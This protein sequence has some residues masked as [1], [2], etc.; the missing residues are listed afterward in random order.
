MSDA[1]AR[2]GNRNL[3]ASSIE[4]FFEFVGASEILT[5]Q[6]PIYDHYFDKRS[7]SAAITKKQRL[8]DFRSWS[9]YF[10]EGSALA[11][12]RLSPTELFLQRTTTVFL[13]Y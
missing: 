5:N 9:I 4:S 8:K 3:K 7:A 12:W 11:G 1:G 10:T 6:W 13:S 2:P